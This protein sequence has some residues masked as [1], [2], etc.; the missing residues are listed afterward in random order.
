MAALTGQAV[1]SQSD[2]ISLLPT[3]L[4]KTKEQNA[5]DYLYFEFI[6]GRAKTYSARGLRL[7]K[8]KAVQ[9]SEKRAGQKFLPI[10]L[11][12]VK[13]DL[14]ETTDLAKNNPE[15]VQRMEKLMDKAHIPLK[16]S[17]K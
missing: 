4:G 6:Q 1:P 7:G 16:N 17:S 3:L 5:H 11:Y 14:G 10:E 9:R 13:D 15:L 8:W 12:N 2:G